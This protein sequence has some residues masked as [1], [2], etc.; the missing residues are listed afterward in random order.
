M[1]PVYWQAIIL[2]VVQGIAEFLP[3]SSSGHLVILGYLMG[4]EEPMD[5]TVA[6]HVGTLFSILVV[7]RRELPP[8]LRNPRL[9]ALVVLATVPVGI[10]GMALKDDFDRIFAA[11][12]Y[13]G[14]GLLVTAAFL[15]FG[16][17]LE[18]DRDSV[19]SLTAWQAL[20]VG[21]FQAVA[22]TPGISRSG[23]TIAGGLLS[24]LKREAAT[25]FSFLIAIPAIS[26]ASL[27]LVKKMVEEGVHRPNFA[28]LGL[29]AG[30]AFVIG[31]LSLRWLI[32][33]VTQRKLHLFAGYCLAVGLSVI[34]WQT[35]SPA[36]PKAEPADV[37]VAA[38]NRI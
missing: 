38:S 22:L 33:M 26:A 31:V 36:A 25:F 13:S 24:G 5:M 12:I 10:V 6:L 35:I 15:W 1:D 17:R 7:Y 19:E 16:Q 14:Y 18:R 20:V 28:A 34:V 29:G 30:I 8:V 2:G 27:V 23:S 3:V 4:V 37:P 32:G 11:P 9:C 21:M